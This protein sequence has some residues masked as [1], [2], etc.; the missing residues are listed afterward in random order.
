M[1]EFLA[2]VA[3]PLVKERK[4][5]TLVEA[6]EELA[7]L[8]MESAR[9]QRRLRREPLR[10]DLAASPEQIQAIE[11]YLALEAEAE[12]LG[13]FRSDFAHAEAMLDVYEMQLD[14]LKNELSRA[15]ASNYEDLT[16]EYEQVAKEYQAFLEEIVASGDGDM[17]V[18]RHRLAAWR[19]AQT[20][21][22]LLHAKLKGSIPGFLDLLKRM[23]SQDE[24]ND[25]LGRND[26]ETART[27]QLMVSGRDKSGS[28]V[29]GY[30]A[31]PIRR[32]LLHGGDSAARLLH[33]CVLLL[34]HAV[35]YGVVDRHSL[36]KLP[37]HLRL[38]FQHWWAAQKAYVP[39]TA[40]GEERFHSPWI[41]INLESYR[42]E[43]II[44]A[45]RC[46]VIVGHLTL[47][48]NALA[49]LP[50]A[51]E[52]GS[53]EAQMEN[54][55]LQ[56]A[57]H[58]RRLGGEV[59][60]TNRQRVE[61]AP[62][63]RAL[64]VSLY[65]GDLLLKEWEISLQ[66]DDLLYPL[67]DGRDGRLCPTVRHQERLW[68]LLPNDATLK[69]EGYAV[70]RQIE[71]DDGWHTY[72]L[73]EL[74]LTAVQELYL[75]DGTQLRQ[76]IYGRGE[77]YCEV[78]LVGTA[79]QIGKHIEEFPLYAGAMPR[80]DIR[81][82]G[83]QILDRVLLTLVV[84]SGRGGAQE[85]QSWLLRDCLA[86]AR[87]ERIGSSQHLSLNL[88]AL[89]GTICYGCIRLSVTNLPGGD[90]YQVF[91]QLPAIHA[92]FDA[93]IYLPWRGA[94][95]PNAKLM[96]EVPQ[97][98]EL[99]AHAPAQSHSLQPGV[100]EVE[101]NLEEVEIM[102]NF[103]WV[104]D[105]QH[106]DLPLVFEIPK[107]L[108]LLKG[109]IASENKWFQERVREELWL[110]DWT[111]LPE[112]ELWVKLPPY[113]QGSVLLTSPDLPR[114]REERPIIEQIAKFDL[115]AWGAALGKGRPV[116]SLQLS[117]LPPRE[118]SYGTST[119]GAT[120]KPYFHEACICTVRSEWE[121]REIGCMQALADGRTRLQ[122]GWVEK[123]QAEE[124][125]L[126]LWRETGELILQQSLEPGLW[127]CELDLGSAPLPGS[128]L[129]Q[130]A[131]IDP[132]QPD[133]ARYPGTS[134]PSTLSIQIVASQELHQDEIIEILS[135]YDLGTHLE[136]TLPYRVRILGR[137][138]GQSIANDLKVNGVIVK[139]SN[140][141]WC[142][143]ELTL[144]GHADV[145]AEIRMSNPVKFPESLLRGGIGAIEARDGEGAMYC[146]RCKLLHWRHDTSLDPDH[147]AHLRGP[148]SR[149]HRKVLRPRVDAS[150][151]PAA[152]TAPVKVPEKTLN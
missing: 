59:V 135:V 114:R 77:Q 2:K 123:G 85:S 134:E 104:A 152:V 12:A 58:G 14:E 144:S 41:Q 95:A 78:E 137:I 50:T 33:H 64:R 139:T 140:Q 86:F 116:K 40:A 101:T 18:A 54:E 7:V 88:A 98:A 51:G 83:E 21:A 92:R 52:T 109:E 96:L 124:R 103:A 102:L 34:R 113:V 126:Y 67:F 23:H 20:D 148:I 48:I 45:Q 91:C 4:A 31:H 151:T 35:E 57:L 61:L 93:P 94:K 130:L 73:L 105:D 24:Q 141:N 122:V 110:G 138:I 26:D 146:P 30:I 127:H 8:R 150:S 47:V 129:I 19:E 128:Y 16:S 43:L 118:I 133:E 74:D 32:Y 10:T 5:V 27:V 75:V 38:P 9:P 117:H 121:A 69:G 72:Q 17:G 37:E 82:A 25:S 55:L 66:T 3:M 100:W 1:G 115:I 84:D 87:Q 97:D 70:T 120:A 63:S 149:F 112:Q 44:P 106:F 29:L 147:A 89:L 22:D 143:G 80:L 13:S 71:M 90:W 36:Q 76:Q 46:K 42:P 132:W 136:L 62:G 99:T 79:S 107:L 111:R 142:W 39:R 53:S 131:A 56:M 68:L 49:S 119:H 125:I 15:N 60:E 28:E 65:D 11:A 6:Q 81:F 145:D 108:W